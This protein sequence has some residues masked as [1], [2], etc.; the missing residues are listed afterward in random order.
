MFS[1]HILYKN[2]AIYY[3][4][5]G[6]GSSLIFLHGFLENKTM[7][8]DY[9]KELS[10]KYR[11]ISI[12]LLGHGQTGCLGYIHTMEDMADAVYAVLTALKLRKVTLIGHSMGGYVALAFSEL[13]P[14]FVRKNIL[15]AA[16]SRADSLEKK[17]NRDRAIDVIKKNKTAFIKIAVRSLFNQ[18]AQD[19]F[20]QEIEHCIEEALK[21]STQGTIAA[22]EGMKIR[23]DREILLHLAPYPTHFI[24]GTQ[25]RIATSES[26]LEQTQ[27]TTCKVLTLQSGHMLHIE[28]KKELLQALISLLKS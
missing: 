24:I 9:Q 17:E 4:D 22:L 2:T 7:W 5:K 18:G 12:D 6:K 27:A 20:P 8:E 21:M 10:T 19:H 25:D 3:T 14:D 16:S 23:I 1:Q 13:Y 28:A 11:V 15:I 26:I